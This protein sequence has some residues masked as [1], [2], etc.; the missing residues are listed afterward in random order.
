MH[1]K[2]IFNLLAV[3]LAVAIGVNASETRE[4]YIFNITEEG[5]TLRLDR[6]PSQIASPTGK[7]QSLIFVFGGGFRN[8]QRDNGYYVP[9]FEFLARNGI[10]VFS[11]DYRLALKNVGLDDVRTGVEFRD[12]MLNAIN[13]AVEDLF[14]AT[15]FIVNH[16]EEWGIDPD[17]I[18]TS[19]SSAGAITSLHAE[20]YI[21]ND[22]VP[23]GALPEGF[24]YAGVVPLAGAICSAEPLHW[25]TVPS[26]M[27]MF[28]GDADSVVPF[29]KDG[30]I[31]GI[32]GMWGS[33]AIS[34]SLDACG[35]PYRFHVVHGSGHEIA[36]F[37]MVDNK[38]E[39]LDF[40]YALKVGNGCRSVS[41]F[42]TVPGRDEHDARYSTDIYR[43]SIFPKLK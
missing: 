2:R 17:A 39:I 34:E 33:K 6:Y 24:N 26:P 43:R 27:L 31:E 18:V 12:R 25:N 30:I 20:Y 38:G 37:P 41:S 36:A 19:G 10:N 7:G 21:C 35:A 15:T 5:D 42:E 40:M 3:L 8:G 29:D 16:S 11:I 22:M 4:T 13:I 23:A 1:M 14:A 28:Q 32:G 9:M